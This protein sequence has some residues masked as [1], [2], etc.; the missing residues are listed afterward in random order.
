[1]QLFNV[2]MNPHL[3]KPM[4][5]R[6]CKQRLK[7]IKESGDHLWAFNA[8]KNNYPISVPGEIVFCIVIEEEI[9]L[10]RIIPPSTFDSTSYP[11]VRQEYYSFDQFRNHPYFRGLKYELVKK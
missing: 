8:L 7:L 1:M 11:T 3:I 6:P 2:E 9:Y 4:F 5:L 10:R